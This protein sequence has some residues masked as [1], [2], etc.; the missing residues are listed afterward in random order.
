[1]DVLQRVWSAVRES[2]EIILLFATWLG[3]GVWTRRRPRRP[4]PS[5]GIDRMSAP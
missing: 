5:I 4:V 3:I 1:M 2:W